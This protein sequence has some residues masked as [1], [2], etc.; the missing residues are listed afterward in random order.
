MIEVMTVKPRQ[1]KTDKVLLLAHGAG[2]PMESDFMTRIA[3]G[4]AASGIIVS[5]FNNQ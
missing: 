3:Q 4:V 5:R 1:P 2:V